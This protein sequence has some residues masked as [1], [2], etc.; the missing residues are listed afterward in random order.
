[1]SFTNPDCAAGGHSPGAEPS[2]PPDQL[3]RQAEHAWSAGNYRIA[4]D[5]YTQAEPE[6]LPSA[7]LL[8]NLGN[9]Y[10]QLGEPGL[11]ALHYQRS[12][13]QNP[14]H[15][16]A[17][18]DRTDENHVSPELREEP[19]QGR[20]EIALLESR[21]HPSLSPTRDDP[22]KKEREKNAQNLRAILD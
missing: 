22:S 21:A 14:E 13:L 16:E 19:G 3:Y 8:Y 11:A 1:M 2:G 4:I 7:D 18:E 9:C 5:L 12:L 17:S 10:Y 6:T 20:V 15:P